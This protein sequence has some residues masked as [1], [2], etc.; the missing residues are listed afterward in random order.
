MR[1]IATLVLVLALVL[2]FGGVSVPVKAAETEFEINEQK[3]CEIL[4]KNSG[5]FDVIDYDVENFAPEKTITYG[6]FMTWV[7]NVVGEK[8]YTSTKS[9]KKAAIKVYYWIYPEATKYKSKKK[10]TYKM[11]KE[12]IANVMYGNELTKTQKEAFNNLKKENKLNFPT[13]SQK[14]EKMSR[15][16]ALY[17]IYVSCLP[18]MPVT[19]YWTPDYSDFI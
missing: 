15:I 9:D 11:A 17:Y 5:K 4:V 14:G 1:K 6:E 8:H 19:E 3:L 2:G 16:E 10:L 7:M 18:E 12:V 13:L